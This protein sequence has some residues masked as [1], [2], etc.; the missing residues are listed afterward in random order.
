MQWDWQV[1]REPRT[2]ERREPPTLCEPYKKY[3]RVRLM[4]QCCDSECPRNAFRVPEWRG[5]FAY[6][7]QESPSSALAKCRNCRDVEIP[8]PSQ[9]IKAPIHQQVKNDKM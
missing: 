3:M 6:E 9:S 7:P 2:L 8:I 1:Q 5:R 4:L